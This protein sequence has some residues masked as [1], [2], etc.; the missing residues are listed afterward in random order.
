MLTDVAFTDSS[1]QGIGDSMQQNIGIG[2][3]FQPARMRNLDGAQNQFSSLGE[4]MHI[5]ADSTSNHEENAECRMPNDEGNPN[6]QCRS[7]L[8]T[9]DATARENSVPLFSGGSCFVINSSF[10]IRASLFIRASNQ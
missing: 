6:D 3:S 10:V 4:P 7:P 2:M 9:A 1:Q 5:I 8:R